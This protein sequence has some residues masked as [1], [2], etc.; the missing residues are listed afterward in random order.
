GPQ[1]PV[2]VRGPFSVRYAPP[3]GA[4]RTGAQLVLGWNIGVSLNS[5]QRMLFADAAAKADALGVASIEGWSGQDLS[6]SVRKKVGGQLAPG[7]QKELQTRLRALRMQMLALRVASLRRD[8]VDLRKLFE[9]SRNVGIQTVIS[10]QV[11]DSLPLIDK[12]AG[13]YG[14]N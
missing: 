9:F 2:E 13:E 6:L 1:T 3:W 14:V 12:L 11:P 7:E 5:F 10:E 4:V 8:E